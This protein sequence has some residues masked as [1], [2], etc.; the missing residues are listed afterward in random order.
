MTKKNK[1]IILIILSALLMLIGSKEYIYKKVV[2]YE[3]V[4][5]VR[6]KAARQVFEGTLKDLDPNALTQQGIIK[7]YQID[8]D[9]IE[10]CLSGGVMVDLIINKDKK[11]KVY[12][13]L[14]ENTKTG[15]LEAGSGGYSS[16]LAELLHANKQ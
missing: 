4:M 1:F 9:S 14:T 3:L 10:H 15:N 13:T 12:D 2:K 16:N 8:F 5:L 6:S 11:L 7:S